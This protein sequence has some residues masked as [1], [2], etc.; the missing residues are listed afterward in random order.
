MRAPKRPRQ[1]PRKP[2]LN[3]PRRPRL[4][5]G[6]PS[7]LLAVESTAS[8]APINVDGMVRTNGGPALVVGA[9]TTANKL[10][11]PAQGIAGVLAGDYSESALQRAADH[12]KVTVLTVQHQVDNQLAA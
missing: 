9:G 2:A 12:F 10:L 4:K 6:F 7:T 1:L 11:A 8:P 5:C 3:V